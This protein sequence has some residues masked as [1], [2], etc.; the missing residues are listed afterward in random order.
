VISFRKVDNKI[1][2]T[3]STRSE[4]IDWLYE[5]FENDED[6]SFQKTFTLSKEDLVDELPEKDSESALKIFQF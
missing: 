6:Y 4:S 2:A 5:K 1:I 3:Y